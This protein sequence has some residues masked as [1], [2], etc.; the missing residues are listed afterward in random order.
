M[1]LGIAVVGEHTGQRGRA[2]GSPAEG[3]EGASGEREIMSLE[4]RRGARGLRDADLVNLTIEGNAGA[5]LVD[6]DAAAQ[7]VRAGKARRHS[8][9]SP[10]LN[11]VTVYEDL[12]GTGIQIDDRGDVMPVVRAEARRQRRRAVEVGPVGRP[13]E[14]RDGIAY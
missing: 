7:G 10:T 6:T 3:R 8:R 4:P 1:A 14:H 9:G 11:R 5:V 13:H 2:L 12:D